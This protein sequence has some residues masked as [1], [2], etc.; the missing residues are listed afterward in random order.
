MRLETG[1]LNGHQIM[2]YD[3]AVSDLA[4]TRGDKIA[5]QCCN[6]LEILQYLFSKLIL[7]C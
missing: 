5:E 2:Y 1:H 6:V 4:Q 3:Y 7:H